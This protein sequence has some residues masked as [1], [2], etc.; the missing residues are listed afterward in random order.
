MH[1]NK[2]EINILIYDTIYMWK[3]VKN[4]SAP[5]QYLNSFFQNRSSVQDLWPFH[6][7]NAA[8]RSFCVLQSRILINIFIILWH[9]ILQHAGIYLIFSKWLLQPFS[10]L[11][12]V[13]RFFFLQLMT[14]FVLSRIVEFHV[15]EILCTI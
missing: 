6:S 1:M 4:H 9:L 12:A 3:T 5:L 8:L 2:R 15:S 10:Q 13:A 14:T 7:V 11:M